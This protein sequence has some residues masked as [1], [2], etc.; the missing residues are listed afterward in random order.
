MKKQNLTNLLSTVIL[1]SL[2]VS[3][4]NATTLNFASPYPSGSLPTNVVEQWAS[5]VNEYSSGKVS[6]KVFPLSLLS[7]AEASPG[8]RDGIADVGFVIM[9]YWPG[10]YAHSNMVNESAMQMKLISENNLNGKGTFAFQGAM[11]EFILHSCPECL[12]EYQSQNQVYTA[13]VTTANYALLCNKKITKPSEMNGTRVRAGG[14][15]W[16]RWLKEFDATQVNMTINDIREALSQGVVDCT[17]AQPSELRNLGLSE[18]VNHVTIDLPGGVYA[19]VGGATFNRDTWR[20]LDV[21]QRKAILKAGA[22]LTA[23][24]AWQSELQAREVMEDFRKNDGQMH[25]ASE[26]FVKL[27][28]EFIEDDMSELV[29]YY[30]TKHG[31][32]NGDALL[33]DFTE[34]LRKWVDRVK[35]A[36]SSEE[37]S[38]IYWEEIFSK[39]DV[40]KY[41]L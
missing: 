21:D 1:I 35:E 16:A 38:E 8:I 18:V 13:N 9:A 3:T 23:E 25:Y 15:H 12:N 24:I 7:A 33:S 14:S 31:V 34:I 40:S 26:Q 27:T 30:E 22:F 41:G 4:A 10:S 6:A 28:K 20:S 29:S 32:K 11:A 17:L 37:L 36:D 2:I 5:K 39:V 19:G